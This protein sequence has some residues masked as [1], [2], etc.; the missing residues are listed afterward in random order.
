MSRSIT[1]NDVSFDVAA[2][3]GRMVDA[4]LSDPSALQ[5]IWRDVY[6]WDPRKQVGTT[7]VQTTKTGA[8]PL[9]NGLTCFVPRVGAGG[10]IVRNEQASARMSERLTALVDAPTTTA[11]LN[12]LGEI[13]QKPQKTLPL[14]LWAALNPVAGYVLRQHLS[15]C[16]LQLRHPAEDLTA[17]LCLPS[18]VR[19]HH[20]IE[21]IPDEA[22]YQAV[23]AQE[24]DLRH[25]A[26]TFVVPSR[27]ASNASLRK[28]ALR[29]RIE[30]IR[31]S[32]DTFPP[33]N[34]AQEG[35]RLDG[36]RDAM[37][38]LEEEWE[39]VSGGSPAG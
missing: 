30:E 3:P 5:G 13:I 7:L 24:P 19:Y 11:I 20:E 33:L 14:S 25:R 9:L 16:V 12:S 21:T 31:T 27:S 28:V 38:L 2:V 37:A 36:L 4:V 22:S 23:L 6:R 35:R 32:I 8:I 10:Q 18:R 1:I 34:D 39:V 15:Y 26:A 29:K 17:Y